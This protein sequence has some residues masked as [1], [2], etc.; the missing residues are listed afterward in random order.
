MKKIFLYLFVFVC[1]AA[2]AQVTIEDVFRKTDLNPKTLKQL[3][4]IPGTTSFCWVENETLIRS[5]L[6][7][8]QIDSLFKASDLPGKPK[9]MPALKL[10]END[11]VLYKQGEEITFF[12]FKTKSVQ[13]TFKLAE[14]SE[15]IDYSPDYNSLAYT[16]G[17]DLFLNVGNY[18]SQVNQNDSP[19]IKFGQSV[20]RNEFGISKGTFWSNTGKYLAFYRLDESMVTRYPLVSLESKPAESKPI[21]YPMAGQTSHHVK[22]GVYKVDSGNTIYLQTGEPADQ[23]LTNVVWSPD[24]KFI[25]VAIVNRDQN[26]MKLNQYNAADGSFVKTLFTETDAQW[27]E[28]E[29]PAHFIPGKNDQFLWQSERN[30]FNQ[31]YHYDLS[32]KLLGNICSEGMLVTEFNGFS[33]TGDACFVTTASDFGMNRQLWKIQLASKKATCLTPEAGNNSCQVNLQNGWFINQ[34]SSVEIAGVSKENPYR[35]SICDAKGKNVKTIL[36][37]AD[38]LVNSGLPK[39]EIVTLK[40]T[41]GT[42]LNARLFKPLNMRSDKKYPVVVYVYGGPHAQMVSNRWLGGG[43]LWMSWM[44]AQGYIVWT[45]DNRGSAERGIEFEQVIHGE[46]GKVEMEDQLKGLEYLKSLPYV[47]YSRIGIHG[48]S[49][50]GFMTTSLMAKNPG[51]FKAGVAGG[52]V[53]DWSLY[54]VMYTERYMDTPQQNPR[55]YEASNVTNNAGKLNDRLMLIHGTVDDVVVWQ[56]SQAFVKKCVDEGVLVD[57]MVYPEHAH[58]VVGKDRLHLYKT[59]SRYLMDHLK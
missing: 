17:D 14:N 24:D 25:L 46:L 49:F 58:N 31:L 48:W 55:G 10:I 19:G 57:Y 18:V 38:P 56:H 33:S 50:G 54:E 22:V 36:Q 29:S 5:D 51:M 6:Q 42:Q 13:R 8:K 9:R 37:A 23:Y 28:P 39:P 47:D 53:T 45:L 59:V 26:E 2:H 40:A 43:N 15:N 30:G 20:H 7:N 16:V 1:I 32:G 34:F 35:A 41:D 52:P 3:Q 11:R 44:A 27:V 4:W 12:D 21:A